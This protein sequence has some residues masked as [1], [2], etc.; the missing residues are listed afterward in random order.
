M[1]LEDN[2]LSGMRSWPRF[3]EID[4]VLAVAYIK[5]KCLS[6]PIT[7]INITKLQKL[8]YCCYGVTLALT[9]QRLTKEYP[10]AWPYGPVFPRTF[11]AIRKNKLPNVF[12]LDGIPKELIL[13][14]DQTVKL[15]G[16]IQ[17]GKLSAWTHIANSPWAKATNNGENTPVRM[18]DLQILR[19]FQ[20]RVVN[21][22]AIEQGIFSQADLFR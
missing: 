8:L 14:I 2:I 11:N 9:G 17:A 20:D 15:F 19:Y 22:L 16:T 6:L 21:P 4:S 3:E 7:D 12:S 1:A 18:D 13:R 5:F 10:Q